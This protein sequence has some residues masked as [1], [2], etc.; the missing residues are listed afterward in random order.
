VTGAGDTV[1]AT[2]ALAL[3]AGLGFE[4]AARL[5]NAAGG[6][7]VSKV[8]TA[9]VTPSELSAALACAPTFDPA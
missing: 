1:A 7:A 3:G 2:L 5:A 6:V 8:G 4:L 9:V